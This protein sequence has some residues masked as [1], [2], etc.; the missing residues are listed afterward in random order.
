MNASAI[1]LHNT[2]SSRE[3]VGLRVD[4]DVPSVVTTALGALPEIKAQRADIVEKL[5]SF[6]IATFDKLEQYALA[7]GHAQALYIVAHGPS[8]LVTELVERALRT[9]DMLYTDASALAKRG[10][11]DG[12]RVARTELGRR[13]QSPT[14]IAEVP[15]NRQRAFTLFM[16]A[17]VQARRAIGFLRWER[18]DL[19]EIAPS[20]Y[21]SRGTK[22]RAA[23]PRT[24]VVTAPGGRLCDFDPCTTPRCRGEAL[25][26][27]EQGSAEPFGESDVDGV[28]RGAIAAQLPDSRE[29]RAVV[30]SLDVEVHERMQ[31]L[32]C[33]L[34][35]DEV[36][37]LR[38]TQ[39][40]SHLHVEQVGRVQALAGIGDL[41]RDT[42]AGR[43]PEQKLDHCRC[44]ED[45]H[46]LSRS[47]RRRAAALGFNVTGV[48]FAR[49]PSNSSRVGFSRARSSSNFT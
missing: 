24:E 35:G 38:A 12:E 41:G 13:E 39:D 33:A 21:A 40:L 45:D 47:A 16:R 7:V 42:L 25:V 34:R 30:V 14:L 9:R 48:L 43:A 49:R 19:D 15:G 26:E 28:V 3:Q 37:A 4:T 22:K 29:Q 36:S 17:Y 44:V 6:D 27:R 1:A 5:P 46:R 18:A 8:A 10:L 23:E 31:R 11:L 2:S 20:L 32:A